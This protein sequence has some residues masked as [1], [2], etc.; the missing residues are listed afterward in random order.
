MGSLIIVGNSALAKKFNPIVHPKELESIPAV[1]FISGKMESADIMWQLKN[2]E[3]K[4]YRMKPKVM[5]SSTSF[6]HMIELVKLGAGIS[7]VPETMIRNELKAQK[8]TH[9]VPSWSS[10]ETPMQLVYPPHRFT[11]KKVS[12]MM[13][14]LER[15]IKKV[16]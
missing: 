14:I 10:G 7:F 8:L 4:V 1:G 5:M 13:L 6:N 15:K 3:G 9:L 11:S 12:E 2:R 16:F